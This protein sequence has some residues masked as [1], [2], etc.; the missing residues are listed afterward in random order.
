MMLLEINSA[1][2]LTNIMLDKNVR[3]CTWYMYT[4]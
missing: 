4:R 1:L 2:K 3:L